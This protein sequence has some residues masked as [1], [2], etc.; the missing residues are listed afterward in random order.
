MLGETILFVHLIEFKFILT[1]KTW[2][3]LYLISITYLDDFG[4]VEL[5]EVLL[6]LT[7]PH[8]DVLSCGY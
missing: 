4:K 5:V 2:K 3:L 6:A 7:C 8:V 1:R